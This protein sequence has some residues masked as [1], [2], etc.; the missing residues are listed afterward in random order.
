[1]QVRKKMVAIVAELL[2]VKSDKITDTA[3]FVD[4]LGADSLE[5]VEAV[6][7]LEHSFGI[8]IVDEEADKLITFGDALN[9]IEDK[10]KKNGK[11][12]NA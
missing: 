10:I 2:D 8:S 1:M 9:L 3:K 4:D 6:A 11:V 12:N 7:A 5:M